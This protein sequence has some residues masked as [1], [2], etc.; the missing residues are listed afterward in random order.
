MSAALKSG[1]K[2]GIASHEMADLYAPQGMPVPMALHDQKS[3]VETH[4]DCLEC[5]G[6]LRTPLASCDQN[7][8]LHQISI[9]LT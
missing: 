5:N 1:T 4:F 9:I 2:R 8:M 3:H 6:S 7:V